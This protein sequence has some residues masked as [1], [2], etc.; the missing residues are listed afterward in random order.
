MLTFDGQ[1]NTEVNFQNIMSDKESDPDKPPSKDVLKI[2]WTC[3]NILE[4]VNFFFRKMP[5]NSNL[6]LIFFFSDLFF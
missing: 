5:K 6:F 3:E 4:E 1:M 2:R